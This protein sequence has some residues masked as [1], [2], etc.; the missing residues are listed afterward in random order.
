MLPPT[1]DTIAAIASPPGGA[2]RGVVRISG[3]GTHRLCAS[4][5]T[6]HAPDEWP[7]PGTRSPARRHP[8][9][10]NIGSTEHPDG[11]LPVDLYLWPTGRSDTGQPSAEIHAVGSPPVLQRLLEKLFAAEGEQVR[12]ARPGEFTLRAFLA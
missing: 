11:Q 2:A 1:D 9:D 3:P 8:G 7:E 6:P 4:F 5:F 12:P 10:W